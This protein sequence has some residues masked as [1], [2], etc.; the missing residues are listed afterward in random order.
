MLPCNGRAFSGALQTGLFRTREHPSGEPLKIDTAPRKLKID[1][2][3]ST[4]AGSDQQPTSGVAEVEVQR[5]TI[6]RHQLGFSVLR[7]L[8]F[9]RVWLTLKTPRKDHT[10]QTP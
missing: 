9:E 6:I 1:A 5:G 3:R 4:D 8:E 2:Y 7:D 10:Q